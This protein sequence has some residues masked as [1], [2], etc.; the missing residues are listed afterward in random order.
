KKTD[1]VANRSPESL[2]TLAASPAIEGA[3]KAALP[4][5]FKP[6][7]ATLVDTAPPGDEWAYEIKFDGYRVLARIDRKAKTRAVKVFTRAGNDWTA[8]FGEQVKAFEQ[9]DIESGWLDGQA[10]VLDENGLPSF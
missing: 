4:A 10:V 8:K 7:L 1:I 9:L 3:L 5:T 2:R 6:Q